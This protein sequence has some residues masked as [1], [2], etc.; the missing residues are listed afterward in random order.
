MSTQLIYFPLGHEPGMKRGF[1]VVVHLLKTF[2]DETILACPDTP[3]H[4]R[5]LREGRG[6]TLRQG[7]A[8]PYT[9]EAW[10]VCLEHMSQRT[11]LEAAYET[12]PGSCKRATRKPQM[13]LA[14]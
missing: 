11:A 2:A 9:V 1:P 5:D 3:A 4:A 10:A 14:L 12:L 8:I 6:L 13:K 7:R